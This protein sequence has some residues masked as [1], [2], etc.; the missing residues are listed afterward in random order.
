MNEKDKRILYIDCFSGISGDMFLGALLD[1]GID[2]KKFTEEISRI[3]PPEGKIKI[4]KEKRN[5]FEGTKFDVEITKKDLKERHLK[6]IKKLLNDSKLD[7]NIAEKSKKMFEELAEVEAKI[8]GSSKEKVHFHEVGAIDSIADIVG[9]VIALELL[10]VNKIYF[11]PIN[12]GTG[13]TKIEHGRVPLPVPA[14]AELLKRCKA[15][16]YSTGINSEL[17]TPT[18][19]LII[20]HFSDSFSMPKIKIQNIGIGFGSKE[21]KESPNFLRVIIGILEKEYSENEVLIETNID[22]MNP[23]FFPSV[24]KKLLLS[25]ALDVFRTPIQMK[26][27]RGGFILSTLCERKDIDKIAD[28]LFHETT[29]IGI[30][31]HSI[32]RRKLNR[33]SKTIKTKFGDAEVK[34]AYLNDKLVNISPEFDSCEKLAK[35]TGLPVKEIYEEVKETANRLLKEAK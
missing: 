20:K 11:S 31:I 14:T 26:K 35:K 24:E 6:D 21:L 3:L 29:T 9:A 13:S 10:Q 7:K 16:V 19:A 25:G 1:L 4:K 32:E 15:P 2:E 8:H 22:D 5:H 12:V 33:K 27:G 18:G 17:V 30:R 34:L 23:E 28:I